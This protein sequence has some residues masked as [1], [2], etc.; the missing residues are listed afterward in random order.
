MGGGL[1]REQRG[2]LNSMEQSVFVGDSCRRRTNMEL[3]VC[4][5]LKGEGAGNVLH[6]R[7]F[8]NPVYYLKCQS[9]LLI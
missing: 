3:D 2:T 1:D 5:G 6:Y 9:I 7:K 4:I 8:Y